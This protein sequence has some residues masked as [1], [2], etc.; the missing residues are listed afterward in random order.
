MKRWI[1]AAAAGI[2]AAGPV[3][4]Q[5]PAALAR[6]EAAFAAGRLAEAARLYDEM[7]DARRLRAGAALA[8]DP[9]L[10]GIAGRLYLR[11][12]HFDH[13]VAYF[14]QA[15]HASVPAAQRR[16]AAIGLAEAQTRRGDRAAALAVLRRLD[17]AG[18]SAGEAAAA[19]L[20]EARALLL[21]DPR[22]ALARVQPLRT[23][24]A[25][26]PA[27]FEAETLAAQAHSLL[28]DR[29]GAAAAADRAWMLSAAL[30]A[31]HLAPLRIALVRAALAAERGDHGAAAAMLNVAGASTSELAADAS[32]RIP[33]CGDGGLT[34]ADHA[35]F[36]VHAPGPVGTV[37]EPVAAS[38]PAAAA[39]F[40]QALAGAELLAQAGE[41][42]SGTVL[43][44]RCRSVPIAD[45]P[46]DMG[47]LAF[48]RWFAARG[49][50]FSFGERSAEALALRIG[51]AERRLGPNHPGLIPL[52]VD[53]GGWLT[54]E[55]EAAGEAA[56]GEGLADEALALRDSVTAAMRRIGGADEA[57]G[58]LALERLYREGSAAPSYEEAVRRH[59]AGAPAV[60]D[61]LPPERGYAFLVDWLTW[62]R[63]LPDDTKRLAIE[64]LA[65]RFPGGPADPRRRAL[66]MR[67]GALLQSNGDGGGAR[68]AYG[69]AGTP[70]GSC[71]MLEEAPTIVE[72]SISDDDFPPLP[73]ENGMRG[74]T[75]VEY[76]VGKDGRLTSM[77]MILSAPAGLFD[78]VTAERIGAF[79]FG[80]GRSGGAAS[81]CTGR[82]QRVIWRL[83]DLPRAGAP[84][85][86]RDGPPRRN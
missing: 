86:A 66:L 47:E 45:F 46:V 6:F 2:A 84:A 22:A 12:G 26:G 43:T 50:F 5:E 78:A 76:G 53:L 15:Q 23:G 68:S 67:L 29:A 81:A 16:A 33:V 79:R 25:A 36:A 24:A 60:L 70:A 59:R 57:I 85:A 83:P 37:V 21:D 39:A 64:R 11:R 71:I 27:A 65:A 35:T 20:A 55:D 51:E 28:G 63:G 74:L 41:P 52:R 13:A 77:R 82:A 48:A 58:P 9:L 38:R 7:V 69:T 30:A 62:D 49:L 61:A 54:A 31:H 56:G 42:A 19:S 73:L 1:L 44:L 10:S 8:P 32:E 34:P 17:R 14:E 75:V 4:A 80:P 40:F 72:G 18:M 3:A